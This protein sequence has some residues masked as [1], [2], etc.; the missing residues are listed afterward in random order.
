MHT[1]LFGT[2]SSLVPEGS[3]TWGSV[4]Q[5]LRVAG[6]L[7]EDGDLNLVDQTFIAPSDEVSVCASVF[8]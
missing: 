6:K 3:N 2:G 4:E 8:L 5:L 1:G 7:D